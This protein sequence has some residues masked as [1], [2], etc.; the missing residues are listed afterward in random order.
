MHK[1]KSLLQYTWFTILNYKKLKTPKLAKTLLYEA[2]FELIE[3]DN[4][5]MLRMLEIR[6]STHQWIAAI[7][8]LE[9]IKTTVQNH[10]KTTV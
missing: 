7:N 8:R 4:D 6:F 2:W 9:Q 1:Y 10:S 3:Y 5:V